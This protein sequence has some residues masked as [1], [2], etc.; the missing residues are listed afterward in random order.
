MVEEQSHQPERAEVVG[1]QA[2]AAQLAR[3]TGILY[4][5]FHKEI[6]G[7]D[8]AD[9]ALDILHDY[10][11]ALSQRDAEIGHILV[12][13]LESDET[14]EW[15][16]QQTSDQL[17]KQLGLPPRNVWGPPLQAQHGPPASGT[18]VDP[19]VGD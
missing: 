7:I 13:A 11:L 19:T 2:E 5:I 18:N 17:R 14:A 10:C 15:L 8:G 4:E 16:G 9:G 3:L 1:K 6:T 12:E